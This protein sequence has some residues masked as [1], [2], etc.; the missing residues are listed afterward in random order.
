V[1]GQGVPA[2]VLTQFLAERRIHVARTGLYTV[3][4]RF[5]V[6]AEPGRWGTVIE[7]LHEFKRFYDT[8]VTAGEALPRLA[9]AH[10]QYVNLPLRRLCDNV[11]AALGALGV[12]RLAHEVA[13]AD[14]RPAMPPAAAYQ[15]LLRGRT[16]S[17]RLGDAAGRVAAA[18]VVPQSGM[19]VVLPGERLGPEGCAAVHYLQALEAVDRTFPGFE[20]D[21]HGVER[22]LDGSFLLR[23]VIDDRR[24]HPSTL[25][26]AVAHEA[27]R[28]AGDR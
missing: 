17:V 10:P 19:P 4:V 6:G 14:A 12:L 1:S 28:V 22:D 5:A 26:R 21:V 27:R 25:P 24:R 11:H 20:L 2:R 3:L 7:A 15:E 13:V 16:E 18:V 9:A 8:G 23:V